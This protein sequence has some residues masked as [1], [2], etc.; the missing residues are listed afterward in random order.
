MTNYST[1]QNWDVTW[2]HNTR[3]LLQ[4]EGTGSVDRAL[5]T[6]LRITY[7]VTNVLCLVQDIVFQLQ[8]LVQAMS[9]YHQD[10][11][12]ELKQA[13]VFPIEVDLTKGIL[14]SALQ[15]RHEHIVVS[16]SDV[17]VGCIFAQ[18]CRSHK[19]KWC[20]QGREM[21]FRKKNLKGFFYDHLKAANLFLACS[22]LATKFLIC[23][24]WSVN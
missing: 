10:C 1:S 9:K 14:G 11:Y 18:D 20:W 17:L 8:R 4:R 6:R 3:V 19:P 22:I 12:Y 15:W 24:R 16:I 2:A 5:G 21:W 23:S 13:D 7:T